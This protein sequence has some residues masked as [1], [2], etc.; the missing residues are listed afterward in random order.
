MK[1]ISVYIDNVQVHDESVHHLATYKFSSYIDSSH[2][3]NNISQDQ[4]FSIYFAINSVSKQMLNV[5]FCRKS[6]VK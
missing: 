5:L 3:Q 1:S 6:N 2:N 4:G